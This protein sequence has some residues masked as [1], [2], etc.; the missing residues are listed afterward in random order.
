VCAREGRYS[1]RRRQRLLLPRQESVQGRLPEQAA[2]PAG[3]AMGCV[4]K[5]SL[6]PSARRWGTQAA[7]GEKPPPDSA[8]SALA[9]GEVRF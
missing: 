4:A 6:L 3:S 2:R 9:V 5:P 1:A 8:V 7:S